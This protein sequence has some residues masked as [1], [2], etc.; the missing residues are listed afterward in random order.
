M[1]AEVFVRC[2]RCG[3][4]FPM[5]RLLAEKLLRV[6]SRRVPRCGACEMVAKKAAAEGVLAYRRFVELR[7]C[8]GSR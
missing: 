5:E 4:H 1:K 8:G 7:L 6:G 2:R 3:A